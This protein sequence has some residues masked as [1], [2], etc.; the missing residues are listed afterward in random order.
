MLCVV[1]NDIK[2]VWRKR[3]TALEFLRNYRRAFITLRCASE[4]PR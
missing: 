2:L 1:V 4:S 3:L